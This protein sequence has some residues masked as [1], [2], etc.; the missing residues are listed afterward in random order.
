MASVNQRRSQVI[1]RMPVDHLN[2]S[3]IL[4]DGE[5]IDV[6]LFLSPSDDIARVLA[7]NE[8]FLP[9]VRN[10]RVVI[11]ARSA[12]ASLAIPT[13]PPIAQEGDL[14]IEKQPAL[15]KLRSGATI[16]G[17]LQWTGPAGRQRTADHLNADEMFF[18]VH[19]EDKTHYVV[20]SHVA[21]VEER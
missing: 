5:H 2:A 20:K 6:V 21:M 9:M 14:P 13:V 8:P 15:V 10:G 16:E 4:H 11:V 17:E 7:S 12:I 3:L 18:K 1:L 19:T